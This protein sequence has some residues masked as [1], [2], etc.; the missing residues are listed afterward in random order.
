MIFLVCHQPQLLFWH[1][2]IKKSLNSASCH[3]LPGSGALRDGLWGTGRRFSHT[4]LFC[5]STL[6]LIFR[7][8]PR[9]AAALAPSI[10]V[11]SRCIFAD[12]LFFSFYDT[13]FPSKVNKLFHTFVT[14]RLDYCPFLQNL[15]I[16]YG[17]ITIKKK[18]MV[19][20]YL[21]SPFVFS[22]QVRHFP[23]ENVCHCHYLAA[24]LCLCHRLRTSV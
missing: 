12:Y 7:F 17:I 4:S 8:C 1:L 24:R 2:R 23:K 19:L 14:W 10:L 6:C 18:Y 5:L 22:T 20:Y 13:I 3:L 16:S 9:F 11:E 21:L 15:P